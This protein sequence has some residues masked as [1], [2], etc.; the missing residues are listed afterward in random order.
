[1][2]EQKLFSSKEQEV[3]ERKREREIILFKLCLEEDERKKLIKYNRRRIIRINEID[4]LT[5][6]SWCIVTFFLMNFTLQ[7]NMKFW[8]HHKCNKLSIHS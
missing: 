5:F 6:V 7:V 4:L 2:K 3:S 1:M 8:N